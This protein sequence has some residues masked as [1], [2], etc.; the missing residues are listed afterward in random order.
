MGNCTRPQTW[1]LPLRLLLLPVCL[2]PPSLPPAPSHHLKA[3]QRWGGQSRSAEPDIDDSA[4]AFSIPP[5][6]F[7]GSPG[8]ASCPT[9][10]CTPSTPQLRVGLL[11]GMGQDQG[12]AAPLPAPEKEPRKDG[13]PPTA[14]PGCVHGEGARGSPQPDCIPLSFLQSLSR[15]PP[16]YRALAVLSS[17]LSQTSKGLPRFGKRP[18]IPFNLLPSGRRS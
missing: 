5:A 4:P 13:S 1:T 9:W 12:L 16:L 10:G 7:L 2:P 6:S 15:P 8:E 17:L 14:S 18:F 3:A 11:V